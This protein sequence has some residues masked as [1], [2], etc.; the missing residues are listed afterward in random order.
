[1]QKRQ[2]FSVLTITS[3]FLV[4]FLASCQKEEDFL[5]VKPDEV[6][7]TS[8]IDD[9]QQVE[10]FRSD[11]LETEVEQKEINYILPFE[12]KPVK[13]T[14]DVIDGFLITEGDI[15]LGE[16]S[17]LLEKGVVTTRA[18]SRWHN[19]VIPYVIQAG[20]PKTDRILA[21]ID[22]VNKKTVLT[23]VPRNGHPNYVE[24][25]QSSSCASY[26]GQIGGRQTIK[27]GNCSFGSIVHEI[28]H[29][30]GLWHEQSRCDRDKYVTIHWENIQDD[31]KGNFNRHCTNAA[32]I[33][34]YN[35]GSVM[36]YPAK[37]FSKNGLNTISIK[38]PPGT[39]STTIG[40]REKIG[41]SDIATIRRIYRPHSPFEGRFTGVWRKNDK[42][43]FLWIGA[44]WQHFINKRQELAGKGYRLKDVETYIKN[45]K[46]LYDGVWEKANTGDAFYQYSNWGDFTNKWRELSNRGYRLVDVETFQSGFFRY[47]TGVFHKGTGKYALYLHNSWDSFTEKWFA[48]RQQGYRLID[49]ESYSVG[50]KQYY[51]TVYRSGNDRNALYQYTKWSDFVDKWRELAANDAHLVDFERFKVGDSYRYLGVFRESGDAHYLWHNV[52]WESFANKR[53]ELR[54]KGYQLIDYDR[55]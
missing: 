35:Y 36:H 55:Y 53:S 10:Q 11:A 32:D 23:L 41:D 9:D 12:E 43:E 33:L 19:A 34:G 45:G 38:M 21:A 47:Y 30:A 50:N 25:I 2:L 49:V 54:A 22:H 8:Q 27:V 29:A 51:L 18:G 44:D 17:K 14:V 5:M 1:M 13:M 7:M 28:C 24:F 40:Q 20:H 39:P 46:R 4:L 31:K 42:G 26:V 37:A 48:L 3:L 16:A 6:E 15:I 52:G